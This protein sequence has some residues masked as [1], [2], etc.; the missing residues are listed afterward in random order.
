VKLRL[1]L[2]INLLWLGLASAAPGRFPPIL[3][4][5]HE[6]CLAGDY[7]AVQAILQDKNI[8]VNK[9]GAAPYGRTALHWAVLAPAKNA[10]AR[11]AIV[12]AL[13]ARGAKVNV[14][15]ARGETPLECAVSAEWDERLLDA[16][17]EAGAE[18]FP[19]GPR[20]DDL[21][22]WTVI[23]ENRDVAAAQFLL[24]R[25]RGKGPPDHATLT[26]I[27]AQV[28]AVSYD[29]PWPRSGTARRAAF[30]LVRCLLEAGADVDTPATEGQSLLLLAAG[31]NDPRMLS[32]VAARSKAPSATG[33][34]GTTALHEA[35]AQH[36]V[37]DPEALKLILRICKV[38]VDDKDSEGNTPLHVAVRAQNSA[39]VEALLALGADATIRNGH[40]EMPIE[41]SGAHALDNGVYEMLRNASVAPRSPE[42]E[43]KRPPQGPLVI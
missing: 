37:C 13:L 34:N 31:T 15:S 6:A 42:P 23:A 30:R 39:A 36:G 9:P 40:H 43:E 29:H 20:P 2:A 27:A 12:R 21:G 26:R 22:H 16:L 4:R 1:A 24:D 10:A 17:I 3:D 14:V 33:P 19:A 8:P 5:L 32:E 11:L 41:I 35:V 7:T 28:F 25:F 38:S 18:I